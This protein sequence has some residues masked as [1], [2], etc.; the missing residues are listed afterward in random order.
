VKAATPG[1]GGGGGGGGASTLMSRLKRSA[2]AN[3]AGGAFGTATAAAGH[4]GD[5]ASVRSG[6]VIVTGTGT[7]GRPMTVAET[8]CEAQTA[9]ARLLNTFHERQEQSENFVVQSSDGGQFRIMIADKDKL[10]EGARLSA[11]QLKKLFLHK[12]DIA[13]I[14]YDTMV[15][16]GIVEENVTND[17]QH[18]GDHLFGMD[19]MDMDGDDDEEEELGIRMR[20]DNGGHSNGL[21]DKGEAGEEKAGGAPADLL[22]SPQQQHMQSH[23][24][25]QGRTRTTSFETST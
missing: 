1:G 5:T 8:I 25:F 6:T 7:G 19:D 9:K 11:V 12:P 2:S 21:R 18:Y 16:E 13:A 15:E 22:D 23:A 14:L 3:S 24:P 17:P 4:E 10:G 20:A